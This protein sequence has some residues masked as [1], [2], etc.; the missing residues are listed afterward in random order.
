VI[1]KEITRKGATRASLLLLAAISGLLTSPALGAHSPGTSLDLRAM[2]TSEHQTA[3]GYTL[4]ENLYEGAARVGTSSGI[5]LETRSAKTEPT[6]ATCRVTLRLSSGT[7]VIAFKIQF[8]TSSGTLS[9]VGGT[10]TYK[11]AR[12]KGTLANGKLMIELT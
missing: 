9:V 2:V 7:I 8:A 4:R 5:C 1:A 11:A 3:S 6:S 10:G 12:G